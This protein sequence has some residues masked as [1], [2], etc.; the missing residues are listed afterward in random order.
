M[1]NE[2]SLK[3]IEERVKPGIIAKIIDGE[4]VLCDMPT[5]K[6]YCKIFNLEPGYAAKYVYEDD[7]KNGPTIVRIVQYL[8]DGDTIKAEKM[9][10]EIN[11]KYKKFEHY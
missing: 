4:V 10:H 3:L 6:D 11:R 9:L 5:Y 2:H 8:L 1:L 7:K